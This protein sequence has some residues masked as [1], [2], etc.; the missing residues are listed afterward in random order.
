MQRGGFSLPNHGLGGKICSMSL[1]VILIAGLLAS[2][3]PTSSAGPL[4]MRTLDPAAT[5]ARAYDP[6]EHWEFDVESGIIWR[7]GH[8]AT[9]L[10]YT[11]LVEELTFKSPPVFD[12]HVGG[13]NLVLRNRLSLLIEPIVVGPESYYLGATGSGSLEWW[14]ASRSFSV[15]LAGG[16][17]YGY[18]D[19]KGYVVPGGQ[20][21]DF[22][23]NWFAYSGMRF[24]LAE[25]MSVTAGCLFQHISNQNTNKINPGLN[26][27]GPMF[28]VEWHF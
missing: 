24:R 9:P 16:G 15:F 4:V 11:V 12:I 27:V 22:N 23:F 10:N 18:M 8:G 6:L 19:S 28:G 3:C 2:L 7:V 20:G 5:T 17:G 14:N 26:A 25:R 1:R 13:G 21:R